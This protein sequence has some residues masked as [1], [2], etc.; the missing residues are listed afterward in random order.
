MEKL[1]VVDSKYRLKGLITVKDIQKK[2]A[3]PN[4]CK[5]TLGRLRVGAAIGATGDFVER[6]AVLIKA[7]VDVLVIDTAHGHSTRVIGRRQTGEDKNS[8]KLT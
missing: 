4:A 2:I 5:D 1:P 3:Y 6:A 7:G 8:R